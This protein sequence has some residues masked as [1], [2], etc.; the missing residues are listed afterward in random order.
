MGVGASKTTASKERTGTTPEHC[1]HSIP[2]AIVAW[3]LILMLAFN[4]VEWFA[5]VHGKLLQAGAITLAELARQLD[6]ALE[7]HEEVELL[8]SG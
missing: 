2:V 1:R 8:W 4:L 3:L 5:R 7:R 6:R